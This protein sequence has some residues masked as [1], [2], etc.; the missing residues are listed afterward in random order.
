[1]SYFQGRRHHD[2][3]GSGPEAEARQAPGKR[4]LTETI[5]YKAASPSAGAPASA[6][7]GGGGGGGGAPLPDDVRTKM[8]RALGADFSAVRIHEGA[9]AASM[10]AVAYTRGN[11]I[12]FQPGQYD[13]HSQAG[14]E[15]L[16]H[17]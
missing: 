13:P 16:G 17:E 12:F 15:L 4:T 6:P 9:D 1:M 2:R 8:E 3:G 5:Q 7:S 14:Q 10:G 11:D